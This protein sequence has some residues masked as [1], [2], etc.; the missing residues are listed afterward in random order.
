MLVFE[1]HARRLAA[2][3]ALTSSSTSSSEM[4]EKL[5]EI[6]FGIL[7]KVCH[8]PSLSSLYFFEPLTSVPGFWLES[9]TVFCS[10]YYSGYFQVA[11]S[12]QKRKKGIFTKQ[13]GDKEVL[14]RYK[15]V[16]LIYVLQSAFSVVITL[17]SFPET[18]GYIWYIKTLN[19]SYW[20]IIPHLTAFLPY[21][22][23]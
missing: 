7:E 14:F 11:D 16:H 2:L 1:V 17:N 21:M 13:G 22:G 10:W 9:F 5:S 20:Y 15:S 18:Y 12:K 6:V 8:S 19:Y 23:I 4:L 3:K